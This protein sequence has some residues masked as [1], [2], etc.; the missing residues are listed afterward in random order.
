MQLLDHG[1]NANDGSLYEAVGLQNVRTNETVGEATRPRPRNVNV[2]TPVQL[3]AKLI[4]RGADPMR[5]TTHV[6]HADTIG[7]PLVQASNQTPLARA[8]Q[9]QDVDAIR[10]MLPRVGDLN[11][12]T[13]GNT[14]LMTLVG[15]GGGRFAG[16]FGAQPAGFRFA[17]TRS[18]IE[19]A[20]ALID[21]GANVNVARATGET[22][23]HL[24][25]QAGNV[26]MIQ[27]LADS[28]ATLDAKTND[29]LTPLDYANGAAGASA[30]RG[31][32]GGGGG[33][34]G[35]GPRAGGPPGPQFEAVALLRKLLGLPVQAGS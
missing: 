33:G 8:L 11:A 4:A 10:L 28:G 17:G 3:I 9:A 14:P 2:T 30:G 15:G 27:L 16:G 34:G 35:G 32:F 7:Q 12:V 5:P 18:A 19:V 29:G 21:A 26:A 25:A 6:L 1:A 31:G 13:Q 24:A 20:R 22:A 23:L